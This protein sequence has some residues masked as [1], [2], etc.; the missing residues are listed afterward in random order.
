M[1]ECGR[2]MDAVIVS[3]RKILAYNLKTANVNQEV[4]TDAIW[5]LWKGFCDK[6]YC[7]F[8]LF[9]DTVVQARQTSTASL[10][11]PLCLAVLCLSC[12]PLF[13]LELSDDVQQIKTTIITIIRENALWQSCLSRSRHDTNKRGSHRNRAVPTDIAINRH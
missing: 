2:L 10:N 12:A 3:D 7:I 6:V 9:V 8:D 1:C 13:L 5:S 11:K 4:R